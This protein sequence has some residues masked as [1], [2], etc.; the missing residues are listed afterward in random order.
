VLHD[1]DIF[2]N[3]V[4]GLRITETAADL[5]VAS[6]IVSSLL[7][8]PIDT[9]WLVLGEVGL[10]GEVRQVARLDRR[11]EE[12]RRHGFR[13]ALVPRLPVGY[14]VPDGLECTEASSLEQAMQLLFYG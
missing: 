12:A 6:A 4:G 2:V 14:Q 7:A 10:T 8:R 5:A 13:R 11:L 1:K 9:D 3:V